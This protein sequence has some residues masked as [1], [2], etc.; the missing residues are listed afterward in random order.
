M[1]IESNFLRLKQAAGIVGVSAKSLSRMI[2][3]NRLPAAKI[4]SGGKTSPF[5]IERKAL[6]DLLSGGRK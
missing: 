6:L 5:L 1:A 2:K 3:D 4:G